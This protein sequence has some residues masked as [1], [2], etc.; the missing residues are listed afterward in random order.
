[1][2][3]TIEV[4]LLQD[5][6]NLGKAGEMHPVKG[7]FARNFLIP[8]GLA[9][10]ATEQTRK[11]LAA[12]KEIEAKRQAKGLEEA[13]VLAGRLEKISLSFSAKVGE[14]DKLYGS[15]T[16]GDIAEALSRELGEEIDKRKVVLGEPLRELGIH[17]VKIS[18][19]GGLEPEITVVVEKEA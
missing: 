17:R 15:I 19:P 7:G 12:R 5:V 9:L 11:E 13:K 2:M 14:E 3:K 8:R 1:M 4:V 6:E 18:L 10:L 16:A